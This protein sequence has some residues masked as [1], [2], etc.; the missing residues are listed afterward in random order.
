MEGAEDCMIEL[1]AIIAPYSLK[2]VYNID[3]TKLF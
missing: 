2:D 3:E 1:Q